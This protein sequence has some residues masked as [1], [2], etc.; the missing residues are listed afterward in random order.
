MAR[1]FLTKPQKEELL[2]L[3]RENQEWSFLETNAGRGSTTVSPLAPL[4]RT[5]D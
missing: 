5:I 2:R 4:K 1:Y 3:H